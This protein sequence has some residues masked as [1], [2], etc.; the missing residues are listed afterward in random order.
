M[1]PKKGERSKIGDLQMDPQTKV[2]HGASHRCAKFTKNPQ[3]II[4]E[5]NRN[6]KGIEPG[7]KK[8]FGRAFRTQNISYEN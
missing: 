2:K 3:E 5:K 1:N 6:R 7:T 4:N 8:H